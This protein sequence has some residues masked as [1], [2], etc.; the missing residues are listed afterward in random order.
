MLLIERAAFRHVD[1]D[2][3]CVLHGQL[4]LLA[5]F[6]APDR[7]RV[8]LYYKELEPGKSYLDL[9]PDRVVFQD[10]L[11]VLNRL[12]R[13]VQIRVEGRSGDCN[14]NVRRSR[15]RSGVPG[16]APV[17]MTQVVYGDLNGAKL[18]NLTDGSSCLIT[19][20]TASTATCSAR[21][22]TGA[23]SNGCCRD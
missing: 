5:W 2:T 18:H 11:G 3:D 16:A 17:L 1:L 14:H 4:E 22:S 15:R 20:N 9:R 23:P 6:G 7:Y 19:G 21:R 13:L 12:V 8:N 10:V